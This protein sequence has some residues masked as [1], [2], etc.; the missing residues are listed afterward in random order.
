MPYLFAVAFLFLYICMQ[1]DGMSGGVKVQF[2]YFFLDECAKNPDF[3]PQLMLYDKIN[4]NTIL[5][6]FIFRLI[7][8]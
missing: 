5:I 7:L 3:F 1:K 4:K 6:L 8:V 2:P